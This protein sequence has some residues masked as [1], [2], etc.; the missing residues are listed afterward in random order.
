MIKAFKATD[1]DFTSN[2]DAIIQ[3]TRARVYNSDNGDYY[4]EI[5]APA[6]YNDFIEPDYILVMN[7]PQGEQAFRIAEIE[8]TARKITA[9]AYHISYDAQNYAIANASGSNAAAFL[10]SCADNT[11]TTCP[12]LFSSDISTSTTLEV[13]NITLFDAINKAIETYGGHIKRDNFNIYLLAEIGDDLG[14]TVEYKKNL[15]EITAS[16]NFKDVCTKLLP[17]GKD[18]LTLDSTYL[19]GPISYDTPHTKVV[20]FSQEIEQEEDE[21]SAHY[22]S[23][24]LADLK[25]QGETYLQEHA[26]PYINYTIKGILTEPTDI[27]DRVRVKD[28]RL[29]V[30]VTT[31]VVSYEYDAIRNKFI[32]LEFGNVKQTLSNLL[33]T[34][35]T[36]TSDSVSYS[37]IN[38]AATLEAKIATK[39]NKLTAGQNITLTT[40]ADNTIQVKAK[41]NVKVNTDAQGVKICELVIDGQ[42][43]TIKA[44][45]S[46]N[47]LSGTT[48]PA[49]TDGENGQIFV[50]YDATNIL[51]LYI[52]VS[53]AWLPLNT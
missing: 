2:G 34:I 46:L 6:G 4:A 9:K 26:L 52:K 5:T 23:R 22:I 41:T 8:K 27:G 53:G 18:G 20:E 13:E 14:E 32:S 44:P 3:A 37:L 49:S 51:N 15:E 7:T 30:D 40:N 16:Y 31:A 43:T 42:T 11:D 21:T 39:S 12:F 19:L 28:A 48:M 10:N 1:T 50:L 36:S 17:V 35:S 25:T 29:G 45:A 24:L 38:N 33:Q 47:I